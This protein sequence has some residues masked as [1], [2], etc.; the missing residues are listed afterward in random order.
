MLDLRPRRRRA[1]IPAYLQK[2]ERQA[3]TN[4][5][6]PKLPVLVSNAK[7]S[8]WVSATES[9]N[10]DPHAGEMAIPHSCPLGPFPYS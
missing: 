2:A 4:C 10:A 5:D 3:V 8:N 6:S 1:N 9:E 7:H